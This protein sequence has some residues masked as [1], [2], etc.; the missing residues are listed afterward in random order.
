M[1]ITFKIASEGEVVILGDGEKVGHIF[2][3][4]GS[5]ND[6]MDAIQVCG[7]DNAF[8]YWG[9]GVFEDSKGKKK[10]DI[11]LLFSKDVRRAK[12]ITYSCAKCY[13][14]PCTC[15]ELKRVKRY[16]ELVEEGI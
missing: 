10:K 9:C 2:S 16:H 1:K 11:Q 3:P 13:N 5:G 7:F 8:D 14:D 6:T 12:N 4:S 15:E